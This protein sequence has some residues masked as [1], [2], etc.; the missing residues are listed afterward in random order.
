MNWPKAIAT[1][2]AVAVIACAGIGILVQAVPDE[3]PPVE[4]EADDSTESSATVT[5]ADVNIQTQSYNVTSH[6]P[7]DITDVYVEVYLQVDGDDK[8]SLGTYDIG[9]IASDATTSTGQIEASVPLYVLMSSAAENS[10]G[11]TVSI[12]LLAKLHF[13]YLEFQGEDIVDMGL[14]LKINLETDGSVTVTTSDSGNDAVMTVDASSASGM[15]GDILDQAAG[16]YYITA[17]DGTS[18]LDVMTLV[19]NNDGTVTLTF[20]GTGMSVDEALDDLAEGSSG[21]LTFACS[22]QSSGST[23][24]TQEQAELVAEMIDNIYEMGGSS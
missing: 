19:I 17:T 2:I 5:G 7:S 16:T 22:G 24:L 12:P 15:L 3:Y 10:D 23:E 20:D 6:L 14:N 4:F 13:S 1:I 11:T 9:T 21:G 8:Y 18:T